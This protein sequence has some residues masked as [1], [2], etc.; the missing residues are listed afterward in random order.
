MCWEIDDSA[1]IMRAGEV[2]VKFQNIL[3]FH[4]PR[5]NEVNLQPDNMGL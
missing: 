4:S 5:N 3:F 2:F 1:A